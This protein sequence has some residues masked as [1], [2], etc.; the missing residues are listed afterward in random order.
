MG[1]AASGS[2][3]PIW[4]AEISSA[5]TNFWIKPH[6]VTTP[7]D[8]TSMLMMTATDIQR[9]AERVSS[10]PVCPIACWGGVCHSRIISPTRP[11]T[12]RMDE[13]QLSD[14]AA[15]SCSPHWPGTVVPAMAFHA[16]KLRNGPSSAIPAGG[17][18]EVTGQYLS[19]GYASL[20][21]CY[22]CRL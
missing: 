10:T 12:K 1:P 17:R 8:T 20:R 14:N 13:R 19:S 21:G 2:T 4:T 3:S 22:R 16:G 11:R 5:P 6:P 7:T 15:K 18:G 9:V